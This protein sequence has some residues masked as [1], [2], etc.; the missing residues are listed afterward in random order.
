V[1]LIPYY[2][3][4]M[5]HPVPMHL[6][7]NYCSHSCPFCFAN[8]NHPKRRTELTQTLNLIKDYK[9]RKSLPARLLQEKYPVLMSN[10]VDP[11]AASNYKQTMPLLEMLTAEGIPVTFQ[12]RGGLGWKDALDIIGPTCW[13]VSMSYWSEEIKQRVEKASPSLE[14]RWELIQTVI[15]RGDK[16]MLGINPYVKEWLPEDHLEKLL[17]RAKEAGVSSVALYTLHFNADQL[18]AMPARDKEAMMALWTEEKAR[19]ASGETLKDLFRA[20]QLAKDVGLKVLSSLQND[21]SDIWSDFRDIYPKTFPTWHDLHVWAAGLPESTKDGQYQVL[22]W[23]NVEQMLDEF[24]LPE[25]LFSE[26]SKY[27]G[28]VQRTFVKKKRLPAK[29]E[30]R[31]VAKVMWNEDIGHTLTKGSNF[32]WAVRGSIEEYKSLVDWEG[33]KLIAFDARGPNE[34]RLYL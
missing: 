1:S 15:A 13:Y 18:A 3:E 10:L 34:D 20:T 28:S 12:T 30:L 16:V 17:V 22:E 14:H 31:D 25:G 8:L 11:F 19:N 2:G 7:M 5:Y 23:E 33:N 6:E 21:S 9:S 29:M 26:S 4:F 24:D 32:G 27:I